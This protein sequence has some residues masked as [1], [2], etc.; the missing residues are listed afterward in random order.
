MNLELDDLEL[1]IARSARRFCEAELGREQRRLLADGGQRPERATWKAAADQGW[2]SLRIPEADGGAGLGL[3]H[4]T[5]L[6]EEV[7]RHLAPGPV[8]WS[9]LAATHLP[10]PRRADLATGACVAT[11]VEVGA[12]PLLVED[13]DLADVVLFV[14]DEGLVLVPREH[15]DGASRTAFDPSRTL[16]EIT[17][18]PAGERVGDAATSR[19]LRLE[20]ALLC[21]AMAA[22]GAGAVSELA[23]EH[24]KHRMQFGQPIGAFQAVKHLCVDAAVQARAAESLVRWAALHADERGLDAAEAVVRQAKIVATEAFLTAAHIAIQVLGS[25]GYTWEHEAHLYLKR[26]HVLGRQFGSVTLHAR[27]VA[28]ALS[29]AA[30]SASPS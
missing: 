6:F 24:A 14:D 13:L 9:H 30:S 12:G 8:L 28:D 15:V 26:A 3:V 17:T 25:M 21:A 11:G 7:G 27:R 23:V 20:G 1:E 16:T 22:G 5:L 19:R 18:V 29:S 10:P 4:A 2:F